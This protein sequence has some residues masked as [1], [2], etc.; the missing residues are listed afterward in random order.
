MR[1]I[2]GSS[3]QRYSHKDTKEFALQIAATAEDETMTENTLL[4]SKVQES[5]EFTFQKL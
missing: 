5:S 4:L 1:S 3:Y 2:D